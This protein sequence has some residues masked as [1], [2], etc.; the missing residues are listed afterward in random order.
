MRLQARIH[1]EAEAK[2]FSPDELADIEARY[3]MGHMWTTP[4]IDRQSI[5]EALVERY[6]RSNRA[7]CAAFELARGARGD[8]RER[9]LRDVIAHHDEAWFDDG[10]QVGAS[11]RAILAVHLAGLDRYDEAEKIA[12]EMVKRFPGAIDESGATL[13]DL[14]QTIRLLRVPKDPESSTPFTRR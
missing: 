1:I 3:R 9:L 7:G 12:V 14:P 6:P 4:P 13:D 5:L 8:E 2:W 10:V 11:A